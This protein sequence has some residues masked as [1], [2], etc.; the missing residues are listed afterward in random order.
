MKGKGFNKR[1]NTMIWISLGRINGANNMK[2]K[3]LTEERSFQSSKN[4]N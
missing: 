4:R 1:E 2:S 3:N